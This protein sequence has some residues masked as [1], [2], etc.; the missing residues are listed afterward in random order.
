MSSQTEKDLLCPV[1]H[2]IF[3]LPVFLSCTHS[4]CKD[5]IKQWW[6]EN[7]I[8]VCPVCKEISP[9]SDPP[10]NL[11]LKNLCEAFLLER[12][13]SKALCSQHSKK[14]RLFCLDHQEPICV[15]CRDSKAHNKHTF[16]PADEAA[17]DHREKLEK[18]LEPLQ[19]KMKLFE[20][21]K[22]N[23]I[24]TAEHIKVQAKITERH[25]KEHFRKLHKFLEEK[26]EARISALRDEEEHKSQVMKEKIEGLDEEIAA[27]SEIIR[28]TEEELKAEDVAFLKNY[29][30]AVER[31]KQRPLPDDPE[32][33][34]GALIDEAKHLGNLSFNIWKMMKEKV[35]YSPVI[36]DPDSAHP[37]LVLSEDLTSVI[38]GIRQ[39]LPDNPERFDHYPIVLGSQGFNSGSHSWDVEVG[40]CKDWKV[41]VLEESAQRKGE[42]LSGLWRIGLYDGVYS[43]RSLPESST[44]LFL[45]KP[46]KIRVQLDFDKGKLS[47][48][49]PDTNTQIHTFTHTFTDRLFPYISNLDKCPLKVLPQ[50]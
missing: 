25:I 34:S 43:A 11:V 41:G 19:D 18:F 16:L 28:A 32:L 48:S 14:L 39:E 38:F 15:I 6:Q 9:Q 33:V 29:K 5:C 3:R 2:D 12:E 44:V 23:S 30:A 7:Q 42:P 35:S 45:D 8:Q 49:D 21:V 50:K 20:S 4:F 31:V 27:L 24:Q 26:E 47:F 10:T 1:C 37:E 13:K 22:R 46:K 36:L 17:G 40:D